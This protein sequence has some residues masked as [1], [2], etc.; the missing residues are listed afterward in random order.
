MDKK[1]KLVVA[2]DNFWPR[3]DGVSSLLNNLL[4]LLCE[5]F[6]VTVISPDFASL[7]EYKNNSAYAISCAFK[8]VKIPMSSFKVSDF[9]F[10]KPQYRKVANAIEGADLVW[11]HTM[12]TVAI[13]AI[14]AARRRKVPLMYYMHSYEW[15]LVTAALKRGTIFA[16]IKDFIKWAVLKVY[17]RFD[18]VIFP[19]ETIAEHYGFFGVKA[20]KA[21]VH[22]G[23]DVHRFSPRSVDP[24]LRAKLGFEAEDIIIGYHGRLS[25]EKDL[26][27]L[28]RAFN[29]LHKTVP[30]TR[31]LIIGDGIEEVKRDLRRKG[32][33]LAGAQTDVVQ[34]LNLI[35]IYVMPSLTET[36]CLAVMEA[37]A[38]AKP[39]I[40]TRVGFIGDYISEGKNGFFFEKK[41]SYS[42]YRVLRRLIK[43][44]DTLA[45]IGKAARATIVADFNWEKQQ[46]LFIEALHK[47]MGVSR[48]AKRR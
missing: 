39:V 44:R 1:K 37:M 2:T 42:L 18:M 29:L 16:Y 15:D 22:M 34:Y 25:R 28:A 43:Q 36:S 3:I 23:I 4:P 30:N 47:A 46:H 8:H 11:V 9:Q 10:A 5:H 27:T 48:K 32:I 35:D 24:E 7:A 20:K 41:N 19:S 6:D 38:C 14:W 13:C 17:K 12:E 26:K 40:S 21:V 45:D 33:V 31:L